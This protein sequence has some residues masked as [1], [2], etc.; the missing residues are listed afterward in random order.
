[1][2]K[3]L[4]LLLLFVALPAMAAVITVTPPA[5]YTDNVAIPA[6][7]IPTMTYT[8]MWGPVDAG[9]G[10]WPNIGSPGAPG[11]TTLTAPDPPAGRTYWY[12]VTVTLDGETSGKA[13][14]KSKMVPF[15]QPGVPAVDV[16]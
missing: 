4:F 15:R 2:R 8:P 13:A 1:M 6:A 3:V 12:T 14:A 11:V 9:Q 5:Q 10:T 7:K 16:R